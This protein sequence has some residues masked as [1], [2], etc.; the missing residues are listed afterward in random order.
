MPRVF[1]WPNAGWRPRVDRCTL[2]QIDDCVGCKSYIGKVALLPLSLLTAG[3][4]L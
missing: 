2:L 4:A 1:S 3:I